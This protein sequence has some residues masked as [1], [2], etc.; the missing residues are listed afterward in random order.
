MKEQEKISIHRVLP[1]LGMIVSAIAASGILCVINNLEIDQILC[2]MFVILG[3]VPVMIFEL[4]FERRRKRIGNNT[5]TTYARI[6]LGFFICC[7]LMVAFSF[8]PEFFR[9]AILLPL[10]MLAYSNETIGI[11]AA[12]FFDVLLAMTTG[13]SFNELLAYIIV[14]M[15]AYALAKALKKRDFRVLIG[16]ILAFVSILFPC[17]FYY[18]SNE[19]IGISS[20]VYAIING[21][22]VALY[23]IFLYPKTKRITIF[24]IEQFY[25]DLLGDDYRLVREVRSYSKAEFLHARKVSEI[26]YKYANILRLNANLAS[27]AGFYYRLGH[28][29]GEP[30]VENGV[31]KA[32]EMCFPTELV[33][34]L[35]EYNGENELPSTPESALVHIID[36]IAIKLEL[37]EN[38]VGTSQ[39]NREVVIYQTLDEF[40]SSG[41]YDKSGLSINAFIKIR[42]LLAKEELLK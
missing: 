2:V 32:K 15:I 9:P 3:F 11:T 29:E 40:S 26:A 42:E 31:K 17:I 34:I 24:E 8:M 36:G 38:E 25:D 6:A 16:L 19:T 13:G 41:L 14:S 27:V 23:A 1:I 21:V 7:V 35:K 33:Q 37:L 4:T 20:F 28:W 39:W 12:L 5:E 30:F 18:L 10:I 22:V